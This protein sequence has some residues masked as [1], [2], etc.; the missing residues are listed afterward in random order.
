MPQN[1]TE[2][3]TS[4]PSTSKPTTTD[5]QP[6]TNSNTRATAALQKNQM[7]PPAA[8]AAKNSKPISH[9]TAPALVEN[10]TKQ[11]PY[12][13][14]ESDSSDASKNS[15]IS[16]R[17]NKKQKLNEEVLQIPEQAHGQTSNN[18]QQ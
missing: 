16:L 5:K 9:T 14:Y 13:G 1:S 10:T 17:N 18:S 11:R 2:Q 8:P 7:T 6:N 15:H 12:E 4:K 3:H